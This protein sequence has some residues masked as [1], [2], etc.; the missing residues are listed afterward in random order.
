MSYLARLHPP[1]K[2]AFLQMEEEDES[3]HLLTINS[4]KGL[5]RNNKLVFDVASAPAL[6]QRAMDQV[7][8]GL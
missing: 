4:H 2:D 8:R 6:C 7:L 3:K 1:F 5:F